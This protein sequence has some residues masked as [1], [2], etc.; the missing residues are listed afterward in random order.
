MTLLSLPPTPREFLS[1][2]ISVTLCARRQ[3]HSVTLVYI[4]YILDMEA[5]KFDNFYV[6]VIIG[7]IP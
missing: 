1:S 5:W 2:K 3:G 4:N 6:R 7:K